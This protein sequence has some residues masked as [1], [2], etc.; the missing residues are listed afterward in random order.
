MMGLSDAKS[1][2]VF[3]ERTLFLSLYSVK[4]AVLTSTYEIS[5]LLLSRAKSILK[6]SNVFS[7]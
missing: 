6:P 2:K 4:L 3:R 7:K 1:L 5:L